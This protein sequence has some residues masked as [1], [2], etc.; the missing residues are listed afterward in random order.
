[1]QAAVSFFSEGLRLAADL[2]RPGELVRGERR[3]GVILCNGFN[4]TKDALV[5]PVA[6]GLAGAGYVCLT[7]DYRWCGLSEGEPRWQVLHDQRL[8]DIQNAVTYMQTLPEVDPDRIGLYGNAMGGGYATYLAATE[9]RVKCM[10]SN[11]GVTCGSRWMRGLR[12][13]SE[14]ADLLREVQEDRMR[15]VQTGKSKYI[16]V[17]QAM[18]V[19]Q[20]DR[21]PMEKSQEDYPAGGRQVTMQCLESTLAFDADALAHR[22]K[23]PAMWIA[24]PNDTFTPPEESISSYERAVGP[25]RLLMLGNTHS[26]IYVD[27]A[28]QEHLREVTQWFRAHLPPRL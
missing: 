15:R 20:S 14:W 8:K 23:V 17:W 27:P 6:V 5:P 1:M 13:G 11:V 24:C 9:P 16:S 28:A 25:K 26:D 3:A 12:R 18:P 7:F 2:Y 22:I 10:V 19:R 4:G 21:D